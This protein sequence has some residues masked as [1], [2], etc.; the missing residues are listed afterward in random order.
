VVPLVSVDAVEE[1]DAEDEVDAADVEISAEVPVHAVSASDDEQKTP[2]SN[3][4]RVCM[5]PT[6][7]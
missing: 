1:G 6:Y 3:S 4:L 2:T 5:P 7:R